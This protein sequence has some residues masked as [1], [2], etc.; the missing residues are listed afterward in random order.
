M[1][2]RSRLPSFHSRA[3]ASPFA[4]RPDSHSY[5][6]VRHDLSDPG[7]KRRRFGRPSPGSAS[8]R[9]SS[10]AAQALPEEPP[11]K[12]AAPPPPPDPARPFFG[13]GGGGLPA[14]QEQRKW[15]GAPW[16]A[17]ATGSRRG[18]GSFRFSDGRQSGPFLSAEA[19][20]ETLGRFYPERNVYSFGLLI[21]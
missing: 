3:G 8:P 14:W 21:S 1:S 18:F 5:F 11:A 6:D 13:W 4:E 9:C 2:T 16:A 7:E 20:E 10:A 17:C 15:G 12:E 19:E